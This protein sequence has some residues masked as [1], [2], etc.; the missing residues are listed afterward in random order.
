[1]AGNQKSNFIVRG[2]L[3]MT[4]FT[5]G[6]ATTQKQLGAFQ[7]GISKS[8]KLI[9]AAIGGVAIGSFIKSSVKLASA[10]ESA[11]KG[12]E[13]I[14]N[15]QGKSFAGTTGFIQDYIKDGL[16]PLTDAVT[17]YKNLTARGYGDEQIQAIMNRLKDSSAFGRQAALTM[18]EAVKSATEGLKNE[19]SILV[20]NAGVTKNVSVIWKEYAKSLGK[21]VESL[22]AAE[23]RQAEY[24]G[25]L[26]ETRY[27]VGDAAKYADTYA[28]RMSALSK[29]LYDIKVNI[30]NAFM[31]LLNIAIPILN[32]FG[33]T[34][35]NITGNLAV[36]SQA[37]F[38]KSI[39]AATNN[40]ES[41]ADAVAGLGDAYE[42]AG[43]KAKGAIA[44][45]DEINMIGA[46][47]KSSVGTPP[48]GISGVPQITEETSDATG[49]FT[50]NIS[51]LK[52][53]LQPTIDA[54]GRFKE[55]LIPIKDFVF[56][57]IKSFYEDILK[58]IGSWV[59]GEGLPKLLDIFSG[60]L[61][62]IDW[63]KLSDAFKKVNEAIAP[64]AIK[65]GEGFIFFVGKLVELLT[66][67]V[68]KTVDLLAKAL[69]AIADVINKIPVDVA[70]AIGG[71]VGGLATAILI[72]K[73]ASAVSGII[74]KIKDAFVGKSGLITLIAKHPILTIAAGIA[75]L[76][77]AVIALQEANFEKSEIGQ[78]IK[79]VDELSESAR[80]LNEEIREEIE[81]RKERRDGIEAEYGAVQI[82]AD[83]YFALADQE[84]LTNDEQL[85]M[86]T[87]AG[88]LIEKIPEL[89]GLID[90]Q[91][92]AYKGTKEEIMGLIGKTKEYYLVQAARESLIEIARRQ[93]ESEKKLKTLTD[94]RKVAEDKLSEVER[95]KSALY[96]EL[97]QKAKDRNGGMLNQVDSGKAL[98]TVEN[99][100][101][102]T[103]RK[104][105][106]SLELNKQRIEETTE[107][108]KELSEEWD[109]ATDYITTYS[110]TATEDINAVEE[111][112]K[113]LDKQFKNTD[114]A[115]KAKGVLAGFV[116]TFNS[117]TTALNS[118]K[119]WLQSINDAINSWQ[120]PQ[121]KVPTMYEAVQNELYKQRG[122]PGMESGGIV[123]GYASGGIPDTGQLFMARENGIAEYVGSWGSQTAVANNDQIR[124]GIAD[125]VK[126]AVVEVLIP[127]MASIV[128]Q[129][130]NSNG[131]IVI[132]VGEEEIARAVI[133]GN[134]RL[135][136]RY[137]PVIQSL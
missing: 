85:L 76:A 43:K 1:M 129:S 36:F 7:A 130:N 104:L 68:S 98:M 29:T 72:F 56:S 52:E 96:D 14:V 87:Y 121:V 47:D 136:G 93:Y 107:T 112:V 105:K 30:G 71:A 41:Q 119:S 99:E 50:G 80:K 89:S 54:L 2:G 32:N 115:G 77:G 116:K 84:S 4:S 38:G 62:K 39:V 120:L 64:F 135:Q 40:T 92:G 48:S 49:G 70:I 63:A 73:T 94:E 75:A 74:K 95:E 137:N 9:S 53:K 34:I 31:P 11:L 19:N 6:L 65:V 45:F 16:I 25:I 42:E 82:L 86:K 59:I 46:G 102:G 127:A 37:L 26:Q 22:T 10:Q 67:A 3:D 100:Y 123:K 79:K 103:L 122:L 78:Y 58:P 111:A 133:K 24:N 109:Y 90:D 57:N 8:M 81:S 60:L 97:I 17:A 28:G 20:D 66:P 101:S 113:D 126:G 108:Q 125:A 5:K 33:T 131:D 106:E 83:K 110:E 69:S 118:V 124:S 13:S 132:Q 91:T 128:A 51:K 61:N 23:K 44:P 15:G 134:A 117:D 21:S 12:L 55:A 18:G 114:L 35:K 88:E 27:M